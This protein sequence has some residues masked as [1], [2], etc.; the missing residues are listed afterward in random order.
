M[1]TIV[2]AETQQT[3]NQWIYEFERTGDASNITFAYTTDVSNFKMTPQTV[4]IQYL[5]KALDEPISW[6]ID[7]EA[8]APSVIDPDLNKVRLVDGDSTVDYFGLVNETTESGTI[9]HAIPGDKP[10]FRYFSANGYG[11]TK[12]M[13]VTF[14]VPS[15]IVFNARKIEQGDV[16]VEVHSVQPNTAPVFKYAIVLD[17]TNASRLIHDMIQDTTIPLIRNYEFVSLLAV[18]K[19]DDVTIT[20]ITQGSVSNMWYV[21]DKDY[22]GY[23]A[24]SVSASNGMFTITPQT[25]MQEYTETLHP[26]P[27]ANWHDV[28]NDS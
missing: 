8:T 13:N 3:V 6:I 26:T 22:A 24:F 10:I 14:N 7:M 16:L 23:E 19:K 15:K 21:Y 27:P 28:S 9:K 4:P 18:N 20:N 17:A 2:D 11:L 25:T 1:L 12:A 5:S